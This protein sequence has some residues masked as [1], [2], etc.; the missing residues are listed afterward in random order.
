[1]SWKKREKGFSDPN[2]THVF[3]TCLREFW[4]TLITK[5]IIRVLDFFHG[6]KNSFIK[7]IH[8][9]DISICYLEKLIL[10]F[11]KNIVCYFIS[12]SMICMCLSQYLFQSII[13]KW[14]IRSTLTFWT[15]SQLC[16]MTTIPVLQVL[17]KRLH[18]WCGKSKERLFVNLTIPLV[19]SERMHIGDLE[20]I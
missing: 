13:S 9:Y 5:V 17:T 10:A 14:N 20:Y 15:L 11:Q 3:I 7:L 8:V 18:L 12:Y 19:M 6:K 1:M 2:C 16:F 4:Y